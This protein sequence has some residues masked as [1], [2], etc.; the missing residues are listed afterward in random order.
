M[1]NATAFSHKGP[2]FSTSSTFLA[3]NSESD[4]ISQRTIF[5]FVLRF[6]YFCFTETRTF[7]LVQGGSFAAAQNDSQR[8]PTWLLK[9]MTNRVTG[10][11]RVEA[12]HSSNPPPINYSRESSCLQCCIINDKVYKSDTIVPCILQLASCEQN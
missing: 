1:W 9:N 5:T 8:L 2:L 4:F 3:G 10:T 7:S 11:C 6:A 12:L